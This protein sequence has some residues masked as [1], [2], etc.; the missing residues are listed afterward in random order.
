MICDVR[1][2]KQGQQHRIDG[3]YRGSGL[4]VYKKKQNIAIPDE[5]NTKIGLVNTKQR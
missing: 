4:G 2:Y 3:L 1:L 5:L